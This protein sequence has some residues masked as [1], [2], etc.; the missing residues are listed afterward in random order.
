[1]ARKPYKYIINL[2]ET[3]RQKLEALLRSGKTERRLADRARIILWA[4]DGITIAETQQRLGCSEQIVLNWRR[5]FLA[6]RDSEGPVNALKDRPR[7][8]RPPVFSP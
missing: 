8:G 5:D 2:T 7:S 1:M 4:A 3:E 6:R